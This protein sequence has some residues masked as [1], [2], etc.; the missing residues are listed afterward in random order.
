MA[1]VV[2]HHLGGVAHWLV[3]TLHIH[4][5]ELTKNKVIIH[6]R[7]YTYNLFINAKFPLFCFWKWRPV[8]AGTKF[9]YFYWC[10]CQIYLA[11]LSFLKNPKKCSATTFQVKIQKIQKLS[12][13]KIFERNFFTDHIWLS[14]EKINSVNM[15]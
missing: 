11:F 13:N 4:Q 9:V 1:V 15:L 10:F 2:F 7:A 14:L 3:L 8:I 12:F 6:D 5:K